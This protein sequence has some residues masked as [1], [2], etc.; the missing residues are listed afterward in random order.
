LYDVSADTFDQFINLTT[1]VGTGDSA[2]FPPQPS[3]L[4]FAANGD[5]LVGLSPDHNLNG[6]I[7]RYDADTGAFIE[8]LVSGIGTPTGIAFLP[9][10][11]PAVIQQFGRHIFYNDSKFDGN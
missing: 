10:D 3:S 11:E 4:A 1:P 9:V 2:G 7:Q 6:A 8:T 5:L